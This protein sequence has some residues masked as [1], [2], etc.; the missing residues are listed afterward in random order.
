[1]T[2]PFFVIDCYQSCALVLTLV[3]VNKLCNFKSNVH[4]SSRQSKKQVMATWNW[5]SGELCRPWASYLFY[6]NQEI[7]LTC[8]S[9][10]TFSRAKNL[11]SFNLELK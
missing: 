1:M 2:N 8:T 4:E 6:V 10:K 9:A 5:S 3:D 11:S 7:G